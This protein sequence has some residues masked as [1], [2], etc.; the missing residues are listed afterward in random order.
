MFDLNATHDDPRRK[1]RRRP[2]MAANDDVHG[3]GRALAHRA[4]PL[5]ESL[6][7]YFRTRVGD[8]AEVDDLVQ[9]VFARI[10]ARQSPAPVEYLNAYVFQTAANVFADR[11]RS[12]MTRRATSHVAFDQ[13]RHAE[14][15]FDPHRILRGKE[16][17][18]VVTA[19]LLSLPERTRTVFVLLRLE[20]RRYK[21]VAAQ[22]RISVSAVEKH[23]VRAMEHL[24]AAVG[25][26]A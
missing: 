21:D 17:L 24:S 19:A 13:D 1:P 22:L 7:R 26:E 9:E 2:L 23:M 8:T 3:A 15:A 12:R 14:E 25:D 16:D 5:R 4:E 10:V 20:E 18:E 11:G 6:G